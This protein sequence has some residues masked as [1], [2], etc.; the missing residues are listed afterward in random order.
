MCEWRKQIKSSTKWTEHV[1]DCDCDFDVLVC[2]NHNDM[3]KFV[4]LVADFT[5]LIAVLC[6]AQLSTLAQL[7]SNNRKK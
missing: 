3:H 5:P 7:N 2:L 6:D 1:R 4:V